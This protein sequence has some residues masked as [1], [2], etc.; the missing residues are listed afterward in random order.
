MPPPSLFSRTIVSFSPSLP[1]GQ[2]PADVV[3]ERHVTEEQDHLAA[4]RGHPK[5]RRDG[6]IDAVGAAIGE[7]SRRIGKG[8]EELLNVADRHRCRDEQRH[9]GRKELSERCHRRRLAQTR[10]AEWRG[11]RVGNGAVCCGPAAEPVA[12]VGD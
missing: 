12:V 9:V 10:G 11:D 2:Q 5:G 3:R 7:D 6:P 8:G 1:G 4:R